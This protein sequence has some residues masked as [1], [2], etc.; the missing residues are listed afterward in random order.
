ML[1]STNTRVWENT[2]VEV[3]NTLQAETG[4]NDFHI[5]T[6]MFKGE[7]NSKYPK[8]QEFTTKVAKEKKKQKLY[9]KNC[10]GGVRIRNEPGQW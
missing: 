10:R 4:K 6:K 3:W 2:S 1:E 5:F 9:V 7:K 8:Q